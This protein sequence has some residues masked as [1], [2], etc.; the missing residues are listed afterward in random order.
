MKLSRVSL[1]FRKELLET[2]RDVRTLILTYGMPIFVYPLIAAVGGKAYTLQLDKEQRETYRIAWVGSD[3]RHLLGDFKKLE[4]TEWST[5]SGDALKSGESH[6]ADV[7]RARSTPS[8]SNS[9]SSGEDQF[10]DA[11]S[12]LRDWMHDQKLTLLLSL[13]E[14][15]LKDGSKAQAVRLYFDE[16]DFSSLRASGH[17]GRRLM[18]LS[19]ALR[20]ERLESLHLPEETL[21]PVRVEREGLA[22][23]HRFV[24]RAAGMAAP[25]LLFV[26]LILS[27]FYPALNS[28]VGER[29]RGTL[30]H[31]ILTEASP[32]ELVTGKFLSVLISSCAGILIYFMS[33]SG[34]I[35]LFGT[36]A[37]DLG[38]NARLMNPFFWL[39]AVTLGIGFFIS[40]LSL[41]LGVIA[42]KQSEGQ[43][44]LSTLML[45]T[46]FPVGIAV[47]GEFSPNLLTVSIP[48][49]NVAVI[50]R[51]F[52]VDTIPPHLLAMTVISNVI[53]GLLVLRFAAYLIRR[54][55]WEGQGLSSLV[56]K[57]ARRLRG[58]VTA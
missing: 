32:L 24:G 47:V 18:D 10:T 1:I 20:K 19:L 29:E 30:T 15:T 13:S 34:S 58:N 5:L 17:V 4:R 56:P 21:T 31:L 11:K 37:I 28:T 8:T 39:P 38:P 41:T 25:F 9:T 48:L 53:A 36:T 45:L 50:A 57:L 55:Y 27:A 54:E 16:T 52:Q 14:Q 33:F 42:R 49:V 2:V 6:V 12:R 26:L 46:L 44:L 23:T 3:T 40:A 22:G 51:V 35:S 7:I 43:A